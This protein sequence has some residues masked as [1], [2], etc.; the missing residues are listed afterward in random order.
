[1]TPA[2]TISFIM[3]DNEGDAAGLISIPRESIIDAVFIVPTATLELQIR[4]LIGNLN[5]AQ[6]WD[7]DEAGQKKPIVKNG[8]QVMGEDGDGNKVPLFRQK[9]SPFSGEFY[10][11]KKIFNGAAADSP[12]RQVI[13]DILWQLGAYQFFESLPVDKGDLNAE[14]QRGK[15]LGWEMH[16]KM[17]KKVQEAYDKKKKEDAERQEQLKK[18]QEEKLNQGRILGPDG[19]PAKAD[20]P[21]IQMP[22]Q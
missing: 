19:E 9:E 12:Q 14:L 16:D 11:P 21:I 13:E 10:N 7:L 1:M 3:R 20:A 5:A 6:I 4:Q 15:F 17:K 8:R 22:N 2:S 18:E